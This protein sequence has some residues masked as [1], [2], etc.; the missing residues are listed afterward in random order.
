MSLLDR[1]KKI[2]PDK[3]TSP[4]LH[5]L[6][7]GFFTFL[8]VP[9]TVTKGGTHIK[10]G[11]DLKRTMVIVVLALQLCYLFGAINIGHQH[12]A[13]FGMYPSFVQAIHL[14]L[15]YGLVQLL[16]IF[17]VTNVV[18][19]GIEF[20]Y[21]SKRGHGIEEGFLVSGAL[22]PLIMPPDI[23]MWILVFSY[24]FCGNN[25]QRSFWRYWNE[26]IKYCFACPSFCLFCLSDYYF[27]R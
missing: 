9:D 3:K 25:R 22:I 18:G 2:E 12:F 14:K 7:D 15:A 5:T 17:I 16:P 4:F 19:L 11:I 6:Y 13:A 23:P 21:A 1:I 27:R 10:D 24:C 8:Y 20:W 26:C